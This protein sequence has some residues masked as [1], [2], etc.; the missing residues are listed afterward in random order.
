MAAGS[1]R[2]LRAMAVRKPTG[3][4]FPPASIRGATP[5]HRLNLRRGNA[6]PIMLPG[7]R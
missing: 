3:S 4:I 2:R 7:K 6:C 5:C 1:M